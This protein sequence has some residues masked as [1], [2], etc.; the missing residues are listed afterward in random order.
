LNISRSRNLDLLDGLD[1]AG[2]R[3]HQHDAVRQGNRFDQIMS[4]E[5]DGLL[6][7]RPEI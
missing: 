5:D 6:G 1:F 2:P 3:A 7:R 4:N